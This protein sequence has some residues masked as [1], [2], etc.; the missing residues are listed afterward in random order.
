MFQNLE[1]VKLQTHKNPKVYEV[2]FLKIG[3][4]FQKIQSPI[5]ATWLGF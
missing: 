3:S 5:E 1:S 4:N 2:G